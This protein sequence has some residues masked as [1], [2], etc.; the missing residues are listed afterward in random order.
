M[1]FMCQKIVIF[2]RYEKTDAQVCIFQDIKF[3]NKIFY[4]VAKNRTFF[5]FYLFFRSKNKFF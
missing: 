2:L 5:P 3:Y 1:Q 4:P